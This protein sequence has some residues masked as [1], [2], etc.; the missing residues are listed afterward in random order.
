M[1][2][3][4]KIKSGKNKGMY[5]GVVYPPAGADGK[6]PP[7]KEFCRKDKNEVQRLVNEMEYQINNNIFVNPG[8]ATIES[9]LKEWIIIYNKNRAVTT[10]SLY[11]MYVDKHIVPG[12]GPVMFKELK[13]IHIQNFINTLMESGSKMPNKEGEPLKGKTVL[14]IISLLNRSLDDAVRNRLI[15]VNPCAAIQ[16]PKKE[17]YSPKIYTEKDMSKLLELVKGTFDE[18]CIVL[19][20]YVGLRR[21]EVFGL[22]WTDIDSKKYTITV[23][24]TITRFD[25]YVEKGPKS[26]SGERTIKVPK[27]VIDLMESYKTSQKIV[28]IRVCDKF[29]PDAY[30]KHFK[31][32]LIDNKLPIIRFHDL[33]H[34][35]GTIMMKYHI[36]DVVAAGRLG[37]ASTQTTKIYQ[38]SGSELDQLAADVL[39]EVYIRNM[40]K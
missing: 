38:H 26:E 4:F 20:G 29:K 23:K 8:K 15:L 37:H 21:G 17:K 36:P 10:Q 34:F 2:S 35:N 27:F 18:I 40:V 24:N 31:K 3:V 25:K 16:K 11:Q 28:S 1:G 19:A 9:F 32:L 13:P 30:T 22:R 14:K 33:R 7:R 5:K 12:I 6:K 39:E